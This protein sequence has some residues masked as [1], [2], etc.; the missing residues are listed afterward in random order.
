VHHVRLVLARV[1][2][3]LFAASWIVVPG[4]G[5]IDLSV[6]WDPD[7]PQVLEAGWGLF[8]TVLVGV[9]FAGVAVRPGSSGPPVAQLAV[10]TLALAVSVVAASEG[11]LVWV[12]VLLALE[13][14][15]VAWLAGISWRVWTVSRRASVP[16]LALAAM[17]VVPWLAYALDM[18]SA[19]RDERPDS[20]ITN[21][22]DHYAVQG[23]LGLALAVLPPLV[24][25]RPALT[26]LV[27]VCAG[28]SAAYL[29]LVSLAWQDAAA[30]FGRAWSVAA[31]AWG[32]CL[33]AVSVVAAVR[34][35]RRAIG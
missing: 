27:P 16:M 1:L 3:F 17:G 19:N 24:A 18:W 29:G 33:V 31:I 22:I 6:T 10:A 14:G 5:A 23:A 32:L 8:F 12:P 28:I 2:A 15:T 9:A 26:P 7:W 25:L 34:R 13:T 30:G 20:D 4:F 21:G 11:P 35:S